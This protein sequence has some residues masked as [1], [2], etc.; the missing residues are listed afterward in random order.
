VNGCMQ[1]RVVTAQ[2][3]DELADCVAG[4]IGVEPVDGRDTC[5]VCREATVIGEPQVHACHGRPSFSRSKRLRNVH[6]MPKA[7]DDRMGGKNLAP[8]GICQTHSWVL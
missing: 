4:F 5:K 1:L 6:R 7:A 2:C 8:D 3:E